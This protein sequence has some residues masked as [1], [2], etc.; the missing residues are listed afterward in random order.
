MNDDDLDWPA[1]IQAAR[2]RLDWIV[3][4]YGLDD[5]D[6]VTFRRL[7]EL[8]ESLFGLSDLA[9]PMCEW[10]AGTN[11]TNCGECQEFVDM[12]TYF[13]GWLSSN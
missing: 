10:Q 13:N 11:A 8:A 5:I 7:V 3:A 6:Y 12:L 2:L 4:E 9:C 1:I